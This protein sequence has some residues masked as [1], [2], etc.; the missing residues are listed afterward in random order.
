MT[1]RGNEQTSEHIVIAP[2]ELSHLAALCITA[3]RATGAGERLTTGY[4]LGP[5]AELVDTPENGVGG[6]PLCVDVMMADLDK[7]NEKTWNLILSDATYVANADPQLGVRS[8]YYFEWDNQM[9]YCAMRDLEYFLGGETAV[10]GTDVDST[11]ELEAS[12]GMGSVAPLD[13][14]ALQATIVDCIFATA[15]F[16]AD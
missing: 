4:K 2:G 7:L 12:L 15:N 3:A 5:L 16:T 13:L 8:T 9:V 11:Q 1:A 6:R 10:E 14:E